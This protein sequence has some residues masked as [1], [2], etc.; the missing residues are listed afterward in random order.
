MDREWGVNVNLQLLFQRRSGPQSSISRFSE[1]IIQ[2]AF[3]DRL[4]WI[5][6][7]LSIQELDEKILVE[8]SQNI[9]IAS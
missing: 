3:H 7:H 1:V 9:D 4:A 8:D 2:V 6:P 5:V